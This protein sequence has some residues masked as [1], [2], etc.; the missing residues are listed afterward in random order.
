MA[1]EDNMILFRIEDNVG[2]ITLNRPDKL[3]AVSWPRSCPNY[4]C[5]CAITMM[6][7]PYCCTVPVGPSAPVVM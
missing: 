1:K 7:E 2:I 6:F 4:Y 3:N 5:R